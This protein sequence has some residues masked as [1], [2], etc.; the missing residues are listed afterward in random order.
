[1]VVGVLL[2]FCC[3]PGLAR[4][5][6]PF[7]LAA[8][9]NCSRNPFGAFPR[10]PSPENK[11]NRNKTPTTQ[12]PTTQRQPNPPTA[13]TPNQTNTRW[14][15]QLPATLN[16]LAANPGLKVYGGAFPTRAKPGNQQNRNNRPPNHQTQPKPQ[17]NKEPQTKKLAEERP[18]TGNSQ[19]PFADKVKHMSLPSEML[20]DQGRD[21]R[22]PKTKQKP[23]P[24]QHA[25]QTRK[26]G[27]QP[28]SL[29]AP[30]TKC[31]EP[32]TTS[33]TEFAP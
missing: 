31:G 4:V 9:R 29:T 2:L 32:K 5:G 11:Q 24:N 18:T 33:D 25:K 27:P 17:T 14:K 12:H 19:R 23:K 16:G 22:N 1:M 10:V 15:G 7:R 21:H 30:P 20:E 8:G 6:R 3:F 13:R 28:A 26:K